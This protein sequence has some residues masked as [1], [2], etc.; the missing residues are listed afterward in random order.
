M[1]KSMVPRAHR[2][3]NQIAA[4]RLLLGGVVTAVCLSAAFHYR[5]EI[6]GAA[7]FAT[8]QKTEGCSWEGAVSGLRAT[9]AQW[10]YEKG[11]RAG[12]T[13]VDV[14]RRF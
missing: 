10:N 11:L 9:D 2:T 8:G 12:E 7:L 13:T 3:S 4:F 1:G 14:S 5:F 6:I